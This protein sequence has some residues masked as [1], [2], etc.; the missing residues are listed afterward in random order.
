MDSNQIK[1]HWAKVVSATTSDVKELL[2]KRNPE[3]FGVC[4]AI[5]RL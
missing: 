3:I 4:R 5:A 2:N 1:S